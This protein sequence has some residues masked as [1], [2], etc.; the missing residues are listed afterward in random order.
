MR[1]RTFR[2]FLKIFLLTPRILWRKPPEMLPVLKEAGV[3]DS[4]G[5]GL[6]EGPERRDRRVSGKRSGLYL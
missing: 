1:R 2:T 3:V 4:G 6:I 5:Q